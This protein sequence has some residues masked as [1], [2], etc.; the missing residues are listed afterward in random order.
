MIKFK[1]SGVHHLELQLQ[2]YVIFASLASADA[3]QQQLATDIP[4]CT[5]QSVAL[6]GLVC[7]A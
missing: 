1:I 4:R 6:G 7:A 2:F 5:P 3:A